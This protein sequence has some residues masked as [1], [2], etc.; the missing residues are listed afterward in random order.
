MKTINL[1]PYIEV[2][3][4]RTL[5]DSQVMGLYDRMEK[6]GSHRAVFSTGD[7]KNRNDFLRYMKQRGVLLHVIHV[8]KETAGI[9]WLDNFDRKTA[10]MHFC[11]FSEFWGDTEFIGRQTLQQ[12]IHMKGADG[13]FVFD[14]FKGLVPVWNTRAID[15]SLE[16]GGVN[17]GTVPK[18]VWNHEKGASE[19]AA[20]IYFTRG[21]G[22]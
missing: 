21:G 6:D 15:F 17:L 12:L 7:I 3:G 8:G 5:T 20:F 1:I 2:D 10:F 14:L 13:D 4:I 18:A 11:V 9:N 22:E 19:D 16:C